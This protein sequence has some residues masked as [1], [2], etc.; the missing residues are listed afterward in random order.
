MASKIKNNTPSN[1]EHI[2]IKKLQKDW[3]KKNK[4]T[5]CPDAYLDNPYKQSIYKQGVSND[6]SN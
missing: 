5:K 2:K 3:L 4:P 1:K 6:S